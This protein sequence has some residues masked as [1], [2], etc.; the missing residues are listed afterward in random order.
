MKKRVFWILTAA[1]VGFIFWNSALDAGESSRLSGSLTGI[2]GATEHFVR[3][4]AHFLEFSL[5]GAMLSIDFA[6]QKAVSKLPFSR[7]ALMGLLTACADETIQLFSA[8]RSS[9]LSDVWIDF[10]GVVFGAAVICL[11][12]EAFKKSKRVSFFD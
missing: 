6:W 11:I 12:L 4:S 3:K 9:Q 10:G 2:L 1:L 8:G 5:L 7:I